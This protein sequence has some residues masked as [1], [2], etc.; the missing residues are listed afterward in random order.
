[1]QSLFLTALLSS[2]VIVLALPE[3]Y[4]HRG[5]VPLQSRSAVN[6]CGDDVKC[7]FGGYVIRRGQESRCFCY[8]GPGE[9]C[10]GHDN[11]FGACETG[12]ECNSCGKCI[13]CA[14]NI[15][16]GFKCYDDNCM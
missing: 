1:M 4:E 7:H 13:G 10:G 3:W 14:H 9:V 16:Y 8:K 11:I 12:L 6:V 15:S 5:E 2:I